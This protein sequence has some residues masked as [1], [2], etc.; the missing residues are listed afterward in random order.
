MGSWSL[1]LTAGKQHNLFQVILG[2]HSENDICSQ[3]TADVWASWFALMMSAWTFMI[4]GDENNGPIAMLLII[5]FNREKIGGGGALIRFCICPP[6]FNINLWIWMQRSSHTQETFSSKNKYNKYRQCV[7]HFAQNRS[8]M[9]FTCQ[10]LEGRRHGR[11]VERARGTG[12]CLC[13]QTHCAGTTGTNT[14]TTFIKTKAGP[15]KLFEN[16]LLYRLF[17]SNHLLFKN[18]LN[19]INIH[20]K[21]FCPAFQ[22][23]NATWELLTRLN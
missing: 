21:S 17:F 19:I 7:R 20:L 8:E 11:K 9:V 12:R 22:L 23:T 13:T 14:H 18:T 6:N 5:G 3:T 2:T 15:N 16:Q 4:I 10:I 1:W